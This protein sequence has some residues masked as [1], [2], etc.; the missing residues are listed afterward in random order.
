MTIF[1]KYLSAFLIFNCLCIPTSMAQEKIAENDPR[2]YAAMVTKQLHTTGEDI[3]YTDLMLAF[4][5]MVD[6]EIDIPATRQ[7]L[8]AMAT[9]ILEMAGPNPDD[10]KLYESL[11]RFVY[12]AGDWNDQSPFSYDHDDP[13][14]R[15]IPNKLIDNYLQSKRGNCVSMPT[16]FLILG[17]KIGLNLTL[18]TAPNHVFVHL[19]L[20]NGPVVNVETTSGANPVRIDWLRKNFHMT[21]KAIQSGMYLKI[22]NKK[23]TGAILAS[24]VLEH[25]SARKKHGYAVQLAD[26]LLG[27]YPEF[28]TALLHKG[29]AFQSMLQVN[30]SQKKNNYYDVPPE[31]AG[32]FNYLAMNADQAFGR[33]IELGY[34]KQPKK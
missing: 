7:K 21:D 28:D 6:P 17:E 25:T 13:L 11:R 8:D 24:I 3:N 22:L 32:F 30:F 10:Q 15:H 14:G 23:Q 5:A 27:I 19:H 4:N 16:L 33:V 2:Y 12:E 31:D 29:Q 26:V 34:Q 9:T 18:S 1:G 20:K